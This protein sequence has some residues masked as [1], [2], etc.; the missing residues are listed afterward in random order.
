M[1]STNN[2]ALTDMGE[3]QQS[4]HVLFNTFQDRFDAMAGPFNIVSAETGKVTKAIDNGKSVVPF[5]G[6]FPAIIPVRLWTLC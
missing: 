6:K 5:P 4:A 1:T 3:N 2:H